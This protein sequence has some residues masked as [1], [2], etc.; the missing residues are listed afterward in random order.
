MPSRSPLV[1]PFSFEADLFS[2]LYSVV[3]MMQSC[4]SRT[5]IEYTYSQNCGLLTSLRFLHRGVRTN[6]EK[7]MASWLSECPYS[8][9]YKPDGTLKP[10]R[11]SSPEASELLRASS[12]PP[13][14][15]PLKRPF[16]H[17]DQLRA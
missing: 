10:V 9:C 11:S 3:N 12:R 6:A 14:F 2:R 5:L 4:I 8:S 16:P 7:K 15:Q 17:I 1:A 13:V